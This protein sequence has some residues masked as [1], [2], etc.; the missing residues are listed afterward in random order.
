MRRL[1]GKEVAEAAMKS[2]VEECFDDMVV[3]S[4]EYDYWPGSA[5]VKLP[6]TI[7]YE[8]GG[9]LHARIPFMVRPDFTLQLPKAFEVELG[10]E[11][12]DEILQEELVEKLTR[13]YGKAMPIIGDAVIRV[14]DAIGYEYREIDQST[15]TPL[16]GTKVVGGKLTLDES[17]MD[18]FE[19]ELYHKALGARVGDTVK[20]TVESDSERLVT[21]PR[22][23]DRMYA[24]TITEAKRIV[25]AD[26][27]DELAVRVLG[28]PGKTVE[29]L[30]KFLHDFETRFICNDRYRSIRRQVVDDVCD[31]NTFPVPGAAVAFWM[32]KKYPEFKSDDSYDH[33]DLMHRG[34]Y[35][36]L[37]R[38]QCESQLRWAF[39]RE[40]L[41]QEWDVEVTE[42][43]MEDQVYSTIV[44]LRDKARLVN[45]SAF[46][47][48]VEKDFD[49]ELVRINLQ[50]NEIL[51]RLGE[52]MVISLNGQ[53][54]G[55]DEAMDGLPVLDED[56]DGPDLM[57]MD[58]TDD[59]ESEEIGEATYMVAPSEA[60]LE[61]TTLQD[62]E[63]T[64]AAAAHGSKE[65]RSLS[66]I[67]S[68]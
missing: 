45:E 54:I 5:A 29:D 42:G 27:T 1:Y 20:F 28:I 35:R 4:L 9:D 18:S 8:F 11:D 31:Q 53:I 50:E 38:R 19:S 62:A 22:K 34:L 14:H 44:S 32:A 21:A 25:P 49:M 13:S 59:N 12:E 33:V 16:F 37:L 60:Q 2:L 36:S 66:S 67:D 30:M 7:D 23:E 63:E 55:Y 61:E 15:Y 65:L 52:K 24:A 56:D 68:Q 17:P 26:I 48:G 51:E 46:F 10:D 58:V 64:K 41:V 39:C 43:E 40:K 47:V 3:Y 57:I 6:P